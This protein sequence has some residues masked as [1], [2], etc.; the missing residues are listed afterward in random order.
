M[1]SAW[2]A[3]PR[4]RMRASLQ[5][6]F[7]LLEIVIVVLIIGFLLAGVLKSQELITSA[8]VKRVAGQL[9]EI[10]SAYF[11]FQDRFKALPGDYASAGAN[12][13]CGTLTCL[14]GNG[15]G[16]VRENEPVVD[17]NQ[18]HEELLLWSHLSTAGFLKGS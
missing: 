8:K 18:P 3:P 17:G 10:R 6:G 14:H 9:D 5:R 13:N 1:N 11:G 12:L 4:N 15:N 2:N 7:T 16:R